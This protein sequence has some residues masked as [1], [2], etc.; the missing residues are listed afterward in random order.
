[1]KIA[2]TFVFAALG[3]LAFA[4][5]SAEALTVCPTSSTGP[6]TTQELLPSAGQ[7]VEL[8]VQESNGVDLI[9]EVSGGI[10]TS[11]MPDSSEG[12]EHHPKEFLSPTTQIHIVGVRLSPTDPPTTFRLGALTVDASSGNTI[13]AVAGESEGV[14]A[15]DEIEGIPP[16]VIAIPIPLPEPA[17]SLMLAAGAPALAAL[18]RRR[19]RRAKQRV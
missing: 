13:V 8:Y 4:P 19:S 7:V 11:F 12:V 18:S 17:Q 9:I 3:M 16:A 5:P 6:C 2:P 14:V 15:S 10:I 1:M